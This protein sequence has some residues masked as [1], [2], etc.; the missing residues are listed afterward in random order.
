MLNYI[1]VGKLLRIFT[2]CT[3]KKNTSHEKV[4]LGTSVRIRC[5]RHISSSYFPL[6]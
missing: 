2:I 1:T 3:V 4:N 6:T 5:L